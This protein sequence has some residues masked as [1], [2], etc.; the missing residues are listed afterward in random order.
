[1]ASSYGCIEVR[2]LDRQCDLLD[3]NLMCDGFLGQYQSGFIDCSDL[4]SGFVIAGSESAFLGF[5]RLGC[6]SGHF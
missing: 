4:T 1:M 5:C 2:A 6:E 3:L